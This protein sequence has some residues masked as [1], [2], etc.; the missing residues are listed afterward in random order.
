MPGKMH[1]HKIFGNHSSQLVFGCHWEHPIF[2]F[3]HLFQSTVNGVDNCHGLR[4]VELESLYSL[5]L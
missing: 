4:F 5:S 3:P 2:L 1:E